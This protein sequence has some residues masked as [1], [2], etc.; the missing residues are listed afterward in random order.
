MFSFI[1]YGRNDNYGYNLH[2]RAA[3]SLNCI[4]HLLD[5]DDEIIFVDYN[6]PDDFP[7]F[8]EAIAD[9]LTD[10]CKK[11]LR[12]IRVRASVHHELFA[13][14]THLKALE[15][16]ARNVALRRSNPDNKWVISTNTDM[17]F[18]P[19]EMQQLSR[20]FAETEDGFY[21][22]PRIEI[23]ETL[24]EGL[25]RYNP[26]QTIT[27]TRR[28]GTSAHLNELVYGPKETLYDGPGDFQ[29]MLRQDLF[30]IDGFDEEMLL[31]WHV[32][33]NLF[34]RLSLHR[35]NIGDAGKHLYGYHCDHTRQ[36][37]QAHEHG[38]PENDPRR[39]VTG[40]ETPYLCEQ[41][42]SWG[43]N[44]H[45][46][47]E[48]RLAGSSASHF[49]QGVEEA[50]QPPLKEPTRSLFCS[51]TYGKQTASPAH[52]ALFIADIL[53]NAP[54]AVKI[55]WIGPQDTLF[56]Y[57]QALLVTN[58]TCV[59][60][61]PLTLQNFHNCEEQIGC[62]VFNFGC[63][64][65]VA[66]QEKD[67]VLACFDMALA[68]EK[69]RHIS[70]QI[71]RR[72]IC[73]NAVHNQF[74]QVVLQN[75]NCAK[76]PFSARLRHGYVQRREHINKLE[77]LTNNRQIDL[78]DFIDLG[79]GAERTQPSIQTDNKQ[80]GIVV[81]GPYFALE[82]GMFEVRGRLTVDE[83]SLVPDRIFNK[84]LAYIEILV[85]S[86]ILQRKT[87]RS[88]NTQIREFSLAL[89]IREED[90]GKPMQ[91][92]IYSKGRSTLSITRLELRNLST[93]LEEKMES[94]P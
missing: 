3:L 26:A 33:S 61:V 11:H 85:G 35:G 6:T 78:L 17:I 83:V 81:S 62:F 50:L 63:E 93:K 22:A 53:V 86:K 70:G 52:T 15:P 67:H 84:K 7:V 68:A 45:S 42:N 57:T 55:G 29:F 25:D 69:Q 92:R 20:V 94:T 80:K 82:P 89:T 74:E 51:E 75:V 9:T 14:K 56:N 76:T 1:V 2:K 54:R 39:F 5:G 65:L 49:I 87:I 90:V 18:V 30:D 77:H 60:F 40:V 43:L 64:S 58:N 4:A 47:E 32:D 19:H 13:E 10:K 91:V 79:N 88:L 28:W 27:Q 72:L 37:T 23:P 16:I 41:R 38:S 31:G 21:C 36:V 8:P 59:E 12:I 34:K 44:N 24:W 71:A 73:A 48:F 66:G 46:L